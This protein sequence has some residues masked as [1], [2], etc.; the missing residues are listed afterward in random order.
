[1]EPIFVVLHVLACLFLILVVLLQPGKG[2]DFSAFGGGASQT[3]FGA[4]G[5]TSLFVKMTV[6]TATLFLVTSFTL[7]YIS[8]GGTRTVL[9][10]AA[11]VTTEAP[12]PEVPAFGTDEE[13]APTG[14]A[15]ET[16]EPPA[17]EQP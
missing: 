5:A 13:S 2:M 11:P 16:P 6:G 9:D 8:S 12:V 4:R 3:F 7:S 10:R 14:E 1:M 17:P 15:E